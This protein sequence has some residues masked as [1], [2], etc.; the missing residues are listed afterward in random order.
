LVSISICLPS[1]LPGES[2]VRGEGKGG[3]QTKAFGAQRFENGPNWG[4]FNLDLGR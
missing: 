2:T 1:L 4:K 3:G